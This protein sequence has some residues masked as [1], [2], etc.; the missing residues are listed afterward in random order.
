VRAGPLAAAISALIIVP[1]AAEHPAAGPPAG[2][3]K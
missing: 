1:Q 3:R 2:L